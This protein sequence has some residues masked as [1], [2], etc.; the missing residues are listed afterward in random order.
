MKPE[1]V[2]LLSF[3]VEEFDLPLEYKQHIAVDQQLAIG[4]DGLKNLFPLLHRADIS[5]TLF[6]T[7][8]FAENYPAAI[9][10]LSGQHEIASHT[11]SHTHFKN[12]D[13]IASRVKLEE[14][15]GEKIY[16]LRMPRMK[17]VDGA[18]VAASGYA[19]N[20]SV[21]PCWIPG[22]YDNR[23]IS[24]TAFND[25][26]ILQVPV[27]VTPNLRIPLF[28]LAFKNMPYRMYIKLA[29]KTLNRD[30]YL[31]LYFHPWEFTNIK[32]FDLPAYIKRIDPAALLEKL[33]RL[34]ND[35]SNEARFMTINEFAMKAEYYNN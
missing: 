19:Y 35:L 26:G 25:N 11:Y 2:I 1:P 27:A 5:T 29:L 23:H 9:K 33:K 21:N 17:Q 32:M 4:F 12:E 15:T 20:S 28:W 8:F 18:L 6:T 30:G 3:D 22:R 13:L 34:V 14:I 16:G 7:A 31:C 24:R 10:E